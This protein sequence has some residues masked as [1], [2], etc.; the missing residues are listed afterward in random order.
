MILDDSMRFEKTM[1]HIS[2]Q[3]NLQC[4]NQQPTPFAING[5]YTITSMLLRE[6]AVGKTCHKVS[7]NNIQYRSDA[8]GCFNE[9]LLL[10]VGKR[11]AAFSG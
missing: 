1:P 11:F 7:K 6:C 10:F 4:R 3:S 2:T 5:E 8:Q 9:R